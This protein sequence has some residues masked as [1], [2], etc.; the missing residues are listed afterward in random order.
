MMLVRHTR[1]MKTTNTFQFKKAPVSVAIE[2][3]ANDAADSVTQF[4]WHDVFYAGEHTDMNGG[5]NTFSQSDLEQ[6]VSNFKDKTT[7]LVI[8]HPEIDAP[9][10]GWVSDIRLT[11]DKR[12][13][14]KAQ[15][16]NIEFAKAVASKAFPN[17]SIKVA[18]GKNGWELR[19]VGYL[20]AAA[21]ALEGMPWQFSQAEDE[22]EPVCEFSYAIDARAG[23]ILL[24]MVSSVRE[25]LIEKSGKEDADKVISSWE[26]DDL[27]NAVSALSERSLD[28]HVDPMFTQPLHQPTKTPNQ[29]I[30]E[31][32]VKTFTQE[33][34]DAAAKKAA[35][36]A[37]ASFAEKIQSLEARAEQ[38]EADAKAL[39]DKEAQTAFAAKVAE[40]KSVVDELVAKGALV[41]AQTQGLAEF[42][43]NLSDEEQAEFAF[44]ECDKD[45]N[46]TKEV[47]QTPFEFAAGFLGSLG[48]TKSP[49]GE[50]PELETI[51]NNDLDARAEAYAKE[52]KCSYSDAVIAVSNV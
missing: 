8:G 37:T 47:K 18:K 26:I 22:Y 1:R 50:P 24:R 49:L 10:Y 25:W 52:H 27:R 28:E 32:D 34:L 5:K 13:E 20:G 6:I 43:A 21:P 12:I 40:A 17:R 2:A 44:S 3:I 38:A 36:D 19:H 35:D 9:A 11:D 14:I 16:V 23:N 45:G 29:H 7:P 41:P 48:K 15:H 4:D 33:Q 30:Q 46:T 42:M 39:K 31:N 51:D